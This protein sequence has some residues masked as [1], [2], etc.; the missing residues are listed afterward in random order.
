MRWAVL[1]G[2]YPPQ[3]GGVADYTR[4]VA[5]GL[6]A[7]GDEVVVFAPPHEGKQELEMAGVAV[8]RLP[9]HF[10]PRGLLALEAAL[11]R[12]HRPDRLLIQYVPHA[13]GWRAL[14]LP[15]AAWVASRA[16]RFAPI[17]VMFHEV[18]LP[19]RWRP[20]SH[21]IIA[22]GHKIMARL[23]AGAA[24]RL[25]ISTPVWGRLLSRICPN[26]ESAEW[27]PIPANILDFPGS[28]TQC[29]ESL[30]GGPVIGHFGTY[31]PQ[32]T[33]LLEP[34]LRCLLKKDSN[35]IGLLLGR[36][37]PEFLD[38]FLVMNPALKTQLIAP[39]ELSPSSLA[40]YLRKCDVLLQPFPDGVTTR[41]TSAMAGFANAVPVATNLGALS[42]PFWQD[43]RWLQVSPSPDPTALSAAA[44]ALL[45]LDPAERRAMAQ[46][47]AALYR[48]RFSIEQTI[49]RL[50]ACLPA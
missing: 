40:L 32:V 47:A 31:S 15:F 2:E 6:A 22:T 9:D 24:E 42:E 23:L 45:A 3:P 34:T 27:L 5:H 38:R 7:A 30:K 14:N 16:G 13:Y 44:E 41:R 10:G 18:A 21:A 37:G 46:A 50:R 19:F 8:I 1:T 26:A 49:A 4:Q 17:W 33:N 20:V 48:Q 25:F 35:R 29:E 36:G 28:P 12:R 11:A 43:A 39:G